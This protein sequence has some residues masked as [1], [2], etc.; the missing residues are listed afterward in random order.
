MDQ[1][2]ELSQ[3][4][5][6]QGLKIR[7]RRDNRR[8]RRKSSKRYF[9]DDEE[10]GPSTGTDQLSPIPYIP[11][12]QQS[13]PTSATPSFK[14]PLAPL[15]TRITN[16]QSTTV[17]FNDQPMDLERDRQVTY[18]PLTRPLQSFPFERRVSTNSPSNIRN[19]VNPAPP[20]VTPPAIPGSNPPTLP[21][22]QRVHSTP[23]LYRS[24]QQPTSRP[25]YRTSESMTQ[26][27]SSV[28]NT[29]NNNTQANTSLP[30]SNS[31]PRIQ[32]P[33][34]RDLIQPPPPPPPSSFN[35][36]NYKPPNQ[37]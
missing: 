27:T 17:P 13:Y 14:R 20:T 22:H 2:T 7:I 25:T 8:D 11:P 21:Y 23:I 33:P 32:L 35:P 37:R 26:P 30:Q 6:N 9:D 3:C 28:N 31:L 29:S 4:L 36:P 16:L 10:A 19:F 12:A 24:A 34:I 18:S 15:P 5:A 1:S